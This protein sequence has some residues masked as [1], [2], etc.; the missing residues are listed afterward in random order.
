MPTAKR[1][2]EPVS[3]SHQAESLYEIT[4]FLFND[5][6]EILSITIMFIVRISDGNSNTENA[7]NV[8]LFL[9]TII[10]ILQYRTRTLFIFIF[11]FNDYFKISI[12]R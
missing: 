4:E 3:P 12:G 7:A 11:I 1:T 8:V 9:F 10:R 2:T 6:I 5:I